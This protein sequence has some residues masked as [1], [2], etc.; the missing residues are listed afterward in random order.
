GMEARIFVPQAAPE[1]KLAQLMVYGA[2]VFAVEGTYD[3]AYRLCSASC[4]HFGWYN[5]NCAVNPGLIEGKKTAGLE[6][7]EQC[8]RFG[9][10]P[11]WIAVSIGDGCTVAGIWKGLVE[12]RELGVVDR[13]PR[14]LG[15]QAE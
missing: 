5:R 8:A 7:A 1:P 2:Q 12:M 13:L 11:D 6:N 10:M 4:E 3:Q 9:G 14:L 15:V